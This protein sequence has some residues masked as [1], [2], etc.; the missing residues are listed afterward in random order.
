MIA[1]REYVKVQDHQLH[2]QLPNDFNFDEV[3]VLIM[4]KSSDRVNEASKGFSSFESIGK[5]GL[6]SESFVEDNEDY[7]Q[8]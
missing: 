7:S 5:T 8:W 4:P 2:I 1:I 6:H 3:E